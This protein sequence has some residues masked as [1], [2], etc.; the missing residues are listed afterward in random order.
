[1]L[2]LVIFDFDGTLANSE[3]GIHTVMAQVAQELQ[4]TPAQV[5][6]WQQMIGIPLPQQLRSLLPSEV[7]VDPWVERYRLI[8]RE[9]E[10][11]FQPFEGMQ[12]V[13]ETLVGAGI[14]VSIASSRPQQGILSIVAQWSWP[15]TFDPIITPTE[16]IHPKPHPE[17]IDRILSHHH[18]DPEQALLIGDTSFD[19]E[20]AMRAGIPG[21]GV[22]WGVHP[23]ARLRE[24][25]AEICFRDPVELLR[26]IES[27]L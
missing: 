23:A 18:I 7:E 6:Q 8:S 17:S 10:L 16:V 3:P 22:A 9:V 4:L 27:Y 25:G 2:K 24:S 14:P 13:V 19:M 21:W 1:M 15:L 20:M 5:Q 26:Q 11:H 12:A